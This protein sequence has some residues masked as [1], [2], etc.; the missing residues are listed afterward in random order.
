MFENKLEQS[1]NEL[2]YYVKEDI[3]FPDAYIFLTAEQERFIMELFQKERE[4]VKESLLETVKEM[5]ELIDEI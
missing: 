5:K 2:S 3:G 1:Y 4:V